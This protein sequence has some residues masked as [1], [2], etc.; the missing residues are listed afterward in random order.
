MRLACLLVV[1]PV[2][3]SATLWAAD[4]HVSPAGDDAN[5][6]TGDRPLKTLSRAAELLQPGDTAWVHAGVYRETVRPA[7]SGE[8]DRPI[9][10]VAAP[11]EKVTV[12]GADVLPGPWTVHQG[13]IWRTPADKRFEQLFV[14]GKMMT[15]ARWPNTP[16]GDLMVMNRASAAEGTDYDV[17]ADPNLPPGDWIGAVLLIWPGDRWTNATRRITDYEPGKLLRVDRDF[18]SKNPDPYHARDP[19]QPRAGNPYVL[20]GSLA[21][22]DM[23]GEWALDEKTGA[24]YLWAPDGASPAGH[25]VEVKQRKWAFDLSKLSSIQVQGFDIFA[26]AV[27]LADARGCLVEDCRMRYVD[28][29]RDLNGSSTPPPANVMTG[30]DNELRRCLIAYSAGTA[31]AM[32]GESNRLVNCVVH[33]ANYLG[34]G[35]GG[36]DLGRSVAAQVSHCS[37][38][39]TGRDIIQHGGSKR[40]RIEYCDLYNANMLNNDSGAIYCWGT[41]GEGGVIAYNWVHDNLGD[42][43]SGVYLDNFSSDFFVHHN[44]IWN[45]SSSAIHLNSD[46][47]NHTVCNNTICLSSR[48]FGTFTYAKYTP[49]M[50]GTRIL[51]NL[52][53][54]QLRVRD[55]SVFVQ[56]ELGPELSHNAPAAVDRDAYPTADSSAID[57]G[58]EVPGI[59]DGFVGKAP[60]LGAYELGGA[61]WVAGAD[62]TDPNAPPAPSH[63]L[64]YAPI[65]RITEQTMVRD[66]LALWLDASDASLLGFDATGGVVEWR[67]RSD[68]RTSTRL[69]NPDIPLRLVRDG[70]NG[71]PV[72]RGEGKAGLRVTPIRPEPGP[73]TVLVVS[74][75]ADA[76]GSNW[77]RIMACFTGKGDEWV[78]PNWIIQ[79]PCTAGHPDPYAPQVFTVQ[80]P[81]GV[82]LDRITVLGATAS[83]GQFLAGDVAEVLVFNRMLRFDEQEAIEAYLRE[84]WGLGR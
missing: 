31:L 58:I 62:W 80:R 48:P 7:R 52:V 8:T 65:S 39:R 75:A 57:A 70:L 84:K 3:L 72:M 6:G 29:F 11:G 45:C 66:G 51:N 26:A 37:V 23:A 41:K 61:R 78:L 10:F 22:L 12:S 63:D 36:L 44:V 76:A 38:F 9:R 14:D 34:T 83:E 81:N 5:P 50:K 43:T 74:G 19:Y 2:L 79:R 68:A 30:A 18:R 49:T 69:S 1:C 24:A 25:T 13:S 55:P 77:Q 33:D 56:G 53:N 35:R 59:T 16:L 60:D 71:K 64:S 73:A 32:G 21:G 47:L 54:A 20:I 4:L 40:I 42:G 28:H 82:A 17:I 67:D 27:S 46:A 15:E